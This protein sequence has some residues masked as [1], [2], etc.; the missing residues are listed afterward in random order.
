MAG[1]SSRRRDA[2]RSR[3][4]PSR[5][6][7]GTRAR[8]CGILVVVALLRLGAPPPPLVE[9]H[10]RVPDVLLG[11]ARVPPFQLRER[12]ALRLGGRRF[13]AQERARDA[14]QPTLLRRPVRRRRLEPEQV[15]IED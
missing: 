10:P 11:F 9:Q 3:A 2:A 8:E 6:Y 7:S 1:V 15:I 13:V 4:A 14:R 5:R 12:V